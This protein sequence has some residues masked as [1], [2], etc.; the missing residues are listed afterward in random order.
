MKSLSNYKVEW[1]NQE[2]APYALLFLMMLVYFLFFSMLSIDKH[3][4]FGTSGFDLGIQDQ[5][6]WLLSQ[7]KTAFS[8]VRGLH[9]FGDHVTF[10]HVL[11]A[12][13]YWVWDDVRALLAFQ[14]AVL[15][16]GAVPIYLIARDKFKNMWTPLIFSLSYLLFPALH[17]LNLWQFHPDSLAVTFLLF[18]FYYATKK[19]Y[20][21]YFLFVGLTL[22]CKEEI[23][24]TVFA[25]GIYVG[26]TENKKIGIIT[27]LT[28]AIWLL[29]VFKVFLPFFNDFGYFRHLYGYS[30]FGQLGSSPAQ[31][32]KTIIFQPGAVISILFT[33]TN[34]NYFLDLFA[35]VGF[36]SLLNPLTLAIALPPL[37]SNSLS[38]YYYTHFIRYHYTAAIIPFIFISAIYGISRLKNKALLN[39]ALVVL[40]LSSFLGNIYIGPFDSSIRNYKHMI[41]T[42]QGFGR[43]SYEY[44]N[45]TN[46]AMKLI[47]EEASVSATPFFVPHLTHRKI[48]Y[49]F[50]NPFEISYWGI[51]GENPPSKDVDYILANLQ[52]L[53]DLEK[54]VIDSLLELNL[55]KKIFERGNIILMKKNFDGSMDD[56]YN[57]IIKRNDA[58]IKDIAL[59]EKDYTICDII[60]SLEIKEECFKEVGIATNDY[61]LCA[62]KIKSQIIRDECFRDISIATGDL[63]LCLTRVKSEDL[64][65][66]CN[67]GIRR[68]TSA[69]H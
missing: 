59:D 29:L 5:G 64:K 6:I 58:L 8:T 4:R 52:P 38:G 48:V 69:E 51:N 67:E 62:V 31:I 36:L 32:I 27:S 7:G 66:E 44:E 35:P 1:R 55:Y 54:I 63:N 28:S 25:L 11:I 17:F 22:L 41:R 42:M 13:L 23:S 24:L 65:A 10:I 16:F 12:P 2:K 60:E 43:V 30:V 20:I 53:S 18:A 26:I 57:L 46:L 37:L 47:P 34:L 50:P 39:S 3:N 40:L 19:M 61:N 14:S 49:E 15:A 45:N 68:L 33:D 21:P 9:I 56:K